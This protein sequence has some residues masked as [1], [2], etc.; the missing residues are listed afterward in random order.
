MFMLHR[1]VLTNIGAIG[2]AAPSTGIVVEATAS[3]DGDGTYNTTQIHNLPSGITAGDL[4]LLF[5]RVGQ[6]TLTTPA[7]FDGVLTA[8][9]GNGSNT[10]LF[11]LFYKTSATGSEG[12]TVTVTASGATHQV[13]TAYRISGAGTININTNVTDEDPPASDT[14]AATENLFI[15]GAGGRASGVGVAWT[16]APT[17]YTGFLAGTYSPSSSS[18]H[19]CMGTAHRL[20]AA[21]SDDPGTFSRG[22]ITT[23]D[24]FTI[25]IEPA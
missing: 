3:T 12:T 23:A 1:G 5:V 10:N 7:I 13:S 15:A 25:V 6:G 19:P 21:T 16:A 11:Y 9:F 17:G 8:A 18:G 20:L 22:A 24:S 4:L 14:V 2:G